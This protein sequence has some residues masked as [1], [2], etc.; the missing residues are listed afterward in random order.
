MDRYPVLIVGPG[1]LGAGRNESLTWDELAARLMEVKRTPETCAEWAALKG[2]RGTEIKGG[3][4]GWVGSA[5]GDGRRSNSGIRSRSVLALDVDGAAPDLMGEV[6]GLGCAAVVH[7]THTPGHWRVVVPL[8]EEVPADDYRRLVEELARRV[9][10]VDPASGKPAQLMFWASVPADDTRAAT[11][12]PGEPL[13]W[14]RFL[15]EAAAAGARESAPAPAPECDQ[16]FDEA[17]LT[18]AL[19]AMRSAPVGMRN[20]TLNRVVFDLARGG[21]ADEASLDAVLDAALDA[22]LPRDEAER[23]VDSARSAGA[24]EY[25]DHFARILELFGIDPAPAGAPA[26][27]D[28]P[29]PSGRGPLPVHPVSAAQTVERGGTRP[30]AE[31]WDGCIPMGAVTVLSGAGGVGKSTITSWLAARV[32]RG[33]LPGALEG[34]PGNVL[35]VQSE[36]DWGSTSVPQLEA[37]GA[38]LTRVLHLEK[39]EAVAR[40]ELNALLGRLPDGGGPAARARVDGA[41]ASEYVIQLPRDRELL[42]AAALGCDARLIVLDVVTSMFEPGLDTNSLVDVRRVL[43]SLGEVARLCDCAVVALHH[44]N[45]GEGTDGARMSGSTAFR[46]AVRCVWLAAKD[47]ETGDV[48]LA[49]DKYNASA[50]RHEWTLGIVGRRVRDLGRF[51]AVTSAQPTWGRFRVA[52]APTFRAQEL[53][54]AV[55]AAG[56]GRSRLTG[57]DLAGVVARLSAESHLSAGRYE[58]QATAQAQGWRRDRDAEKVVY[59]RGAELDTADRTERWSDRDGWTEPPPVPVRTEEAPGTAPS[60]GNGSGHPAL[61]MSYRRLRQQVKGVGPVRRSVLEYANLTAIRAVA[62]GAAPD[63]VEASTPWP[64]P[65]AVLDAAREAELEALKAWMSEWRRTADGRAMEARLK[66]R[67]AVRWA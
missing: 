26:G 39:D 62:D 60:A 64:A 12:F 29:G 51:A 11:R 63:E 50:E 61:P 8:S 10:G 42:L 66:E 40:A 41:S 48:V 35:M 22:G 58:A 46:D 28:R 1:D 65:D 5:S 23:T 9:H 17:M 19:A 31:L 56:E 15:K 43:D 45:K 3:F 21:A 16:G 18:D 24:A 20:E 47:A 37:A 55:M 44:W 13:D 33:A 34:R 25:D 53:A 38:D 59:R 7:P 6:W 54:R 67:D 36:N 27:G 14:R 52:A 30:P 4:G 2:V 49:Q 32:S 57:E